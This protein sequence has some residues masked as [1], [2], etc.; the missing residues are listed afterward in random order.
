MKKPE[1]ICYSV[2]LYET[3]E[4]SLQPAVMGIE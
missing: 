3:E 1:G 4:L 2:L